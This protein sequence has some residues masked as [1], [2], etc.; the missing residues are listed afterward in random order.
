[1]DYRKYDGIQASGVDTAIAFEEK[2]TLQWFLG[3]E[4]G[5]KLWENPRKGS[6]MFEEFIS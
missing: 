5:L 4:E 1:M 6:I 3:A 2:K